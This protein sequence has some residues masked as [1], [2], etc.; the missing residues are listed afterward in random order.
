MQYKRDKCFVTITKLLSACFQLCCCSDSGAFKS[1]LKSLP[2]RQSCVSSTAYNYTRQSL[3]KGRL[4][5]IQVVLSSE[6]G[7]CNKCILL[8]SRDGNLAFHEIVINT[9]APFDENMIQFNFPVQR[10]GVNIIERRF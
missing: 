5:S 1:V 2:W 8:F 7:C 9:Q 3:A 4:I 10:I 6:V